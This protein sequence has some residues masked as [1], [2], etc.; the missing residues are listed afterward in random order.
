MFIKLRQGNQK[1]NFLDSKYKIIWSYINFNRFHFTTTPVIWPRNQMLGIG[2]ENKKE[3]FYLFSILSSKIINKILQA[4]LKTE[5]EKD[6]LVSLTSIKEFVRVPK[7]TKDNQC[8]KNEIIKRTEEILRLEK[9]ILSDFVDFSKVMLQKFDN[10]L[11]EGN[12][13]ILEKSDTKIELLIKDKKGLIKKVLSEKH[14]KKII[15][16]EKQKIA[17]SELKNL[18]IIDYEK[19]QQTKDYIDDLVFALYFNVGLEKLGL[20]H[21]EKIKAKCSRNPYYKLVNI[22]NQ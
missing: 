11:V 9:K 14:S 21:A 18:L 2:S 1:Y 8:I 17:L 20:N 13:L 15:D 5:N 4:N 16:L 6:Y 12:N 22:Q 10:V 19:Q 3:L 7:I